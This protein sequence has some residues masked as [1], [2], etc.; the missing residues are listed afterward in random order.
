VLTL[1][2]IR[3][4]CA[5]SLRVDDYYEF[6]APDYELHLTP[7]V[8]DN[9]NT[10]SSID[11]IRT[12]L[13]QQLSDL[14]G[15]PSVAMHEVPPLFQRAERDADDDNHNNSGSGTGGGAKSSADRRAHSSELYDKV[16]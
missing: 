4:L 3:L 11:A 9:L 2:S 16:D 7:E 15:A 12:E 10:P 13:L 1:L 5:S 14:Q 6:F 8:M